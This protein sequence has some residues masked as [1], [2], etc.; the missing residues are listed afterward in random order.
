M[1]KYH[2]MKNLLN[3]FILLLLL[4]VIIAMQINMTMQESVP[5]KY[6]EKEMDF[7]PQV[8]INKKS[9]KKV[10]S[11]FIPKNN[12]DLIAEKIRKER[13][14]ETRTMENSKLDGF[15]NRIN[16]ENFFN[17]LKAFEKLER[18]I[19]LESEKLNKIRLILIEIKIKTFPTLR[20][21]Y[22]KL[23][24]LKYPECLIYEEEGSLFAESQIFSTLKERRKIYFE[25]KDSL[26]MMNFE[27]LKFEF[28]GST[29]KRYRIKSK[30]EDD[31]V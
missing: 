1:I 11:I 28:G 21:D 5:A 3:I 26:E 30:K 13:E 10:L 22:A 25:L 14:I 17:I 27:F 4:S 23:L 20:E 31:E 9:D 7:T 24:Q 2:I 12:P 19:T 16:K 18:E 6:I 29:I 15:S 8:N